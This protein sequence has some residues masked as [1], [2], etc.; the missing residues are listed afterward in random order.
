MPSQRVDTNV[1]TATSVAD[2]NAE[3]T[4]RRVAKGVCG[5]L[6]SMSASPKRPA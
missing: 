4:L 1:P 3:K 2:S 5:R 6:F